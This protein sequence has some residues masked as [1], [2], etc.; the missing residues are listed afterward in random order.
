M[1]AGFEY[2]VREVV[3]YHEF[4]VDEDGEGIVDAPK[5]R[6]GN[7]TND[8]DVVLCK[9]GLGVSRDPSIGGDQSRDAYWLRMKEHF[10]LRNVSGIDRSARSLRSRWSTIN[11]D[12]QQ[13]AAAQKA[14]DKLNPSG[15]NDD[16]RLNISQNLFKGEEKRA[17]KGEIKKG[18]PF[19]LPHC[20]EVLKDDEK[21]KKREDIDDLDLSKKRKRT[22]DLEDDDEEDASSEDGKRSPTPNSVSYSKPKRPDGMKKDATEK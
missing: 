2:D 18:R 13:W 14:V 6:G 4:E 16:D 17:K 22:I 8:E 15:T 1:A 9:T 7:Y 5:G 21:W 20:Y 11:R 12:C 3:E 10:D 19:T